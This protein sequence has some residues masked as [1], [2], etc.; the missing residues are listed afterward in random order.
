M[1]FFKENYLISLTFSKKKEKV[2]TNLRNYVID[3]EKLWCLH[4]IKL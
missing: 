4:F 1:F 3:E 2:I